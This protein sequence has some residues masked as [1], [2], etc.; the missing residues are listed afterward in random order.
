MRRPRREERCPDRFDKA[1]STTVSIGYQIDVSIVLLHI[2][3]S[4]LKPCRKVADPF[5]L[6]VS[7][8]TVIAVGMPIAGHPPH[9]SGRAEF[10]HPA[11]T[12]GV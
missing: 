11:P 12:S 7:L 4:V 5:Y 10:P 1:I 6:I 9:R 3:G 8:G 2:E